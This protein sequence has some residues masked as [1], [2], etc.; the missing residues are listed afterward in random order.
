MTRIVVAFVRGCQPCLLTR[1]RRHRCSNCPRRP[2]SRRSA[3][4]DGWSPILARGD[5][6]AR[7][8]ARNRSDRVVS[9]CVPCTRCTSCAVLRDGMEE[10]LSFARLAKLGDAFN[11]L[12]SVKTH[13]M[14]DAAPATTPGALPGDP[15]SA[16]L[17]RPAEL[18]YRV[19]RRSRVARL[20]GAQRD[21]SLRSDRRDARRRHRR[22]VHR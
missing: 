5:V 3:P 21:P 16:R 10:V 1:R 11:G 9:R 2:A 22:H 6:R 14:L 15:L 20:G 12:A 19:D 4:R 18:A 17:H 13:A 7:T 8:E